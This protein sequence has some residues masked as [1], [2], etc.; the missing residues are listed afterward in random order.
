M[1]EDKPLAAVLS[2]FDKSD[3]LA[4]VA[5]AK[6]RPAPILALVFA[7]NIWQDIKSCPVEALI[8]FCTKCQEYFDILM[9]GNRLNDRAVVHTLIRVQSIGD[10][11]VIVGIVN[12]LAG[13]SIGSVFKTAIETSCTDELQIGCSDTDADLADVRP[14][15]GAVLVV[16]TGE[17]VGSQDCCCTSLEE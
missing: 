4:L 8:P 12:L 3:T 1:G 6:S 15:I 14:A 9:C 2:G 17:D 5:E 13:V 7:L 10:I 11:S 16:C